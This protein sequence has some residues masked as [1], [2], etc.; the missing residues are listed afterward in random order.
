MKTGTTAIQSWLTNNSHYLEKQGIVYPDTPRMLLGRNGH[1]LYKCN[2]EKNELQRQQGLE[3]IKQLS[4]KYDKIILSDEAFWNNGAS[5]DD[6]WKSLLYF[7][8]SNKIDLKV[9]VYLRRQDSFI[10][11]YWKQKIKRRRYGK[12]F[13]AFLK[14]DNFD[15]V[16]MDYYKTLSVIAKNIGK[17]NILVRPYEFS[18]FH[19]NSILIDFC[20]SVGIKITEE[21]KISEEHPNMSLEGNFVE[22]RRFINKIPAYKNSSDD[23]MF[24]TIRAANNQYLRN[25]KPKKVNMASSKKLKEYLSRFDDSNAKVAKEFL[26]KDDGKL[27]NDDVPDLPLYSI[28]ENSLPWDLTSVLVSTIC[29]QQRAIEDLN[30]KIVSINRLI[31]K[32]F[33]IQGE[34]QQSTKKSSGVFNK[35][36]KKF[37]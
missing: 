16:A 31:K 13:S 5:D 4:K 2:S 1:F 10:Q 7:T 35:L 21:L 27:F 32:Q 29:E 15:Y 12:T 18:Q 20:D 14:D 11:S 26:Q 28:D 9:I 30:E 19:E 22:I 37:R 6:F 24:E 17:E 8:K 36:F 34:K 33:E 3:Q 25:N 23:F